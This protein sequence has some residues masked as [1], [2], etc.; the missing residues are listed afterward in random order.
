MPW[1]LPAARAEQ[2][3]IKYRMLNIRLLGQGDLRCLDLLARLDPNVEFNG[4]SRLLAI[5][6]VLLLP[7][8]DFPGS[9]W[10]RM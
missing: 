2:G 4:N 5:S 1:I 9:A 10:N 7:L 3:R 8:L 6:P